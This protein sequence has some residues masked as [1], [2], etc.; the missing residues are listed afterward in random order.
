L[1]ENDFLFANEKKGI[2]MRAT[3]KIV[4][5][6]IMMA[7]SLISKANEIDTTILKC[8]EIEKL[9]TDLA[10]G[11]IY[12]NQIDSLEN[13]YN[14]LPLFCSENPWNLLMKLFLICNKYPEQIDSLNQTEM[15]FLTTY[16]YVVQDKKF[17]YDAGNNHGF[18]F[19][20]MPTFIKL[21]DA[22]R[23]NL[24]ELLSSLPPET[25]Q[26][27]LIGTLIGKNNLFFDHYNKKK[28]E[29]NSDSSLSFKS[30]ISTKKAVRNQK[31][32]FL[33]LKTSYALNPQLGNSIQYDYFTAEIIQ[34]QN[35]LGLT[36]FGLGLNTS[37]SNYKIFYNGIEVNADTKVNWSCHIYYNY[38]FFKESFVKPFVGGGLG[39]Q[40]R[41]ENVATA[42]DV[43]RL[44]I[45]TYQMYPEVGLLFGKWPNYL[46][47]LHCS[48]NLNGYS[49]GYAEDVYEHNSVFNDNL[50]T[51]EW[52]IGLSILIDM[53]REVKQKAKMVGLR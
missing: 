22:I 37:D 35:I 8:Y 34:K 17:V 47:K 45:F 48:Y 10:V 12:N 23:S 41:E 40:V 31:Q 5:I 44:E 6:L 18:F 42:D 50:Y 27:E 33:S 1:N 30:F 29:F 36:I 46:F 14:D 43:E 26:S 53:D 25:R 4:C 20:Q 51:N 15:D 32:L 21:H 3:F 24:K 38:T 2:K 11:F 9:K 28:Y 19:N 13:L 52:R 39:F 16:V 49:V 7:N